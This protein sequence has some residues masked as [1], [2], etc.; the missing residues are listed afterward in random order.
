MACAHNEYPTSTSTQDT[1]CVN[2]TCTTAEISESYGWN[3]LDG[4]AKSRCQQNASVSQCWACP[5]PE[6]YSDNGE[7]KLC[8]DKL[9]NSVRNGQHCYCRAGFWPHDN[10]AGGV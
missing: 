10:S 5:Y 6:Y 2:C 7:C 4:K 8:E 9:P 1:Y 3:V